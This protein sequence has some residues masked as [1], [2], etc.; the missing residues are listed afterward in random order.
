MNVAILFLFLLQGWLRVIESI[1]TSR[2]IQ[3]HQTI[4]AIEIKITQPLSSRML[5]EAHE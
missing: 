5:S 2:G 3:T 1:Y 4:M